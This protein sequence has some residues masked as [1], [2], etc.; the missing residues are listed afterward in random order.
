M[1]AEAVIIPR[2]TIRPSSCCCALRRILAGVAL[3]IAHHVKPRK[4]IIPVSQMH[5]VRVAQCI[6]EG[7][8]LPTNP[9]LKIDSS[10][11]GRTLHFFNIFRGLLFHQKYQLIFLRYDRAE[12]KI[13]AKRQIFGALAVT[14]D[15]FM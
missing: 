3:I 1:Q 12:K 11:R 10:D 15:C 4:Q 14:T 7:N 13:T 5:N 8:K 9:A 6:H 2:I